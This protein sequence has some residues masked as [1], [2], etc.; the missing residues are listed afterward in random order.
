MQKPEY[1]RGLDGGV[2][3]ELWHAVITNVG[4][5]TMD[6]RNIVYPL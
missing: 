5:D 1:D 4:P 6:A 2:K 3:E